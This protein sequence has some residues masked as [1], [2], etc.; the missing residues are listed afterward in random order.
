MGQKTL[1]E[2]VGTKRTRNSN[3]KSFN[4]ANNGKADDIFSVVGSKRGLSISVAENNKLA[5]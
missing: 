5:T 2:T 4:I 1:P 3:A